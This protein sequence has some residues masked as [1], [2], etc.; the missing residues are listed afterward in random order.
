MNKYSELTEQEINQLVTL[1]VLKRKY[2][3]AI[4]FTFDKIQNCFFVETSGFFSCPVID[5][6]NS[7]DNAGPLIEIFKKK[8]YIISFDRHG[9]GVMKLHDSSTNFSNTNN[10]TCRAICECILLINYNKESELR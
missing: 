6:C 1:L 8:G 9:V 4:S 5:Y 3:Q 7:W 10:N 2:K